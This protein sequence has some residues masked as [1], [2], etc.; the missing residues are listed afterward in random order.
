MGVLSWLPESIKQDLGWDARSAALEELGQ[1]KYRGY[2]PSKGTVNRGWWEGI[3]DSALGNTNEEI[4]KYAR[5]LQ[6][7]NVTVKLGK[8]VSKVNQLIREAGG[9]ELINIDYTSTN[10]DIRRQLDE[11]GPKARAVLQGQADAPDAGI[12][13]DTPLPQISVKSREGQRTEGN[14][15]LLESPTY[16]NMIK[17]Q[18][19]T[20]RLALGQLSLAE[21][22][23]ANQMTMAMMD[24]QL[25]R[26]RQDS[27]D[28][29]ADRKDRQA[30]IMQMMQGLSALGTSIAI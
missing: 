29:R 21:Q 11:L 19:L 5:D 16:Q 27:Q 17:Q 25:E 28:R 20:N 13:M 6:T 8:D 24:N 30:M 2:N 4:Q 22:R 12:T 15:A 7:E 14:L 9:D 26:R 23:N 1:D 3:R 10:R 18:N